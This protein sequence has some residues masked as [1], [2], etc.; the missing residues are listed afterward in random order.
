MAR[1]YKD[2][3]Q[4]PL[5]IGKLKETSVTEKFTYKGKELEYP[6][7]IVH[8]CDRCGEQFVGKKTMKASAK[9][10]RDFYREVDGLLTSCQIK[11]IRLKLGLNQGAASELLGGGAK[12]F[13][14]YENCDVIQSEAMDNLLRV[15]K[16][17]PD[18]LKVIENK[19]KPTSTTVIQFQAKF[20]Q[21][22]QGTLVVNYGK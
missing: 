15:L 17:S 16:D 13:A 3:E 6:G 1:E 9:R 22:I 18:L 2:G 20:G 19:N 21:V 11:E 7:Y 14:R 8:E 5:C 10:L 4:C 12:S